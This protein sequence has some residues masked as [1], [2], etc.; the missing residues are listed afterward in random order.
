MTGALLPARI[1]PC[2]TCNQPCPSNKHTY[3]SDAC[4]PSKS[5]VE[6]IEK[7]LNNSTETSADRPGEDQGEDIEMSMSVPSPCKTPAEWFGIGAMR[8]MFEELL[9]DRFENFAKSKFEPLETL[10]LAQL[11]EAKIKAEAAEKRAAAAEALAAEAK[12]MAAAAEQRVAALEAR[13]DEL[14]NEN[15]G[16]W[17]SVRG[18][19]SAIE[20]AV[21]NQSDDIVQKSVAEIKA[22]PTWVNIVRGGPSAGSP[23]AQQQR[24]INQP[25]VEQQFWMVGLEGIEGKNQVELASMVKDTLDSIGVQVSE[26]HDVFLLKPRTG[27]AAGTPRRVKFTV[28]TAMQARL[29]RANRK[30]LRDV[31]AH[32]SIRDVLSPEEQA[33]QNT[34]WPKFLDARKAGKRAYFQRGQLFVDGRAVEASASA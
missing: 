33:A 12:A 13:M 27:A 15:K 1:K 7:S 9:T 17:L 21:K 6:P 29:V 5:T 16:S 20:G 32:V 22:T 18:R 26:L 8:A 10:I 23:P 31:A 4:K 11:H 14:S 2:K 3:C 19:I 30:Q 34:L 24:T 25:P 28:M